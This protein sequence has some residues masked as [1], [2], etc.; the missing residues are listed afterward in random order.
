MSEL[1]DNLGDRSELRAEIEPY[2]QRFSHVCVND[3]EREDLEQLLFT[4]YVEVNHPQQFLHFVS[5]FY[6]SCTSLGDFRRLCS[7]A[8]EFTNV[9]QDKSISNLMTTLVRGRVL[10]REDTGAMKASG[11]GIVRLELLVDFLCSE[12]F[13]DWFNRG[14]EDLSDEAIFRKFVESSSGFVDL[15]DFVHD[16]VSVDPR[17][18]HVFVELWKANGVADCQK[19]ASLY[20]RYAADFNNY[21]GL[22][23]A[24]LFMVDK[25]PVVA[26]KF[27]IFITK[28]PQVRPDDLYRIVCDFLDA[29]DEK[30]ALELLSSER[31]A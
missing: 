14:A 2:L 21:S 4:L 19:L 18:L 28:N 26:E 22:K 27:L 7:V 31:S 17:L 6:L 8:V 16:S 13:V 12:R 29:N 9:W 30:E 10:M 24:A 15:L 1:I 3:S 20:K 11:A 5:G 23:Y 25:R